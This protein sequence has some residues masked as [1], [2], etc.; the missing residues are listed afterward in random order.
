MG[1]SLFSVSKRRGIL[2]FP[3]AN[4]EKEDGREEEDAF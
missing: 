1:H 3:L 4:L 2:L